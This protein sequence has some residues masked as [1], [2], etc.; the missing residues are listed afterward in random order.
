MKNETKYN[1]IV[2]VSEDGEIQVFESVFEYSDGFKGAVG[3][4]FYP[5]TRDEYEERIK[6]ESI[7]EYLESAVSE[8]GIPSECENSYRKWAESIIEYD[9][10]DEFMFDTSYSELWDYM[11]DELGLTEDDAYIFECT[12]GGR[13][14]NKNF[15]GNYNP[16][17]SEIIREYES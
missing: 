15:C 16:E 8:D 2:N 10:Q 7:I 11:R 17:L 14:F 4:R 3:S 5:V 9:E 6:L 12:G 13:M 1:K